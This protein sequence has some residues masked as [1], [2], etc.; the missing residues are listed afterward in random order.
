MGMRNVLYYY[1]ICIVILLGGCHV[2]AGSDTPSMENPDFFMDSLA[3]DLVSPSLPDLTQNQLLDLHH[4]LQTDIS[5]GILKAGPV[6][7][8]SGAGWQNITM[9]AVISAPGNY[10][11]I[12]D[13]SASKEEIGLLITCSD[14]YI[15]GDR[16]TFYGNSTYVCYGIGATALTSLSNITVFNFNTCGCLGGIVFERVIG[17]EISDT[18]HTGDVSGITIGMSESIYISGNSV[19]GHTMSNM[20]HEYFGIAGVD[21]ADINIDSNEISNITPFPED[22]N[23]AGIFLHNARNLLIIGNNITGP[24]TSGG[25]ILS[26]GTNSSIIGNEIT[27][28]LSCGGIILTDSM[29]SHIQGNEITGPSSG[30]GIVLTGSTHS[31]I[32]GNNITGPV[33]TGGITLSNC[34]NSG[35]NGSTI[36]G[37]LPG[38]GIILI[39]DMNS[40]IHGNTVTGQSSGGGIFLNHG[41]N[42]DIHENA[43]TGPSYGIVFKGE[44][45]D[46]SDNTVLS[47]DTVGVS[48]KDGPGTIRNNTVKAC[49]Y[50]IVL[51]MDNSDI[52]RN[53]IHDNL[54]RGLSILGTNLTLSQNKLTNNTCNVYIDGNRIDHYLHHIDHT[55]L[56]NGRPLLYIRD[57]SGDVVG[58]A[59]NPAMV[60]VARSGNVT[61]QNITTGGNIAGIMLANVT[62][63]TISGVTDTG[64]MA[65]FG[66]SW[67]KG[68]TVSDLS[69]TKSNA[70]GFILVEDTDISLDRCQV[71]ETS[72]TGYYIRGS[73]NIVLNSCNITNFTQDYHEE[74]AYGMMIDESG[75]VL[76]QNSSISNSPY[77]GIN[78]M[79][80]RGLAVTN[81]HIFDN[82]E[83]GLAC[84]Q[85]TPIIVSNST[86]Y[87]NNGAGIALDI[88]STFSLN[89]NYIVG[90]DHGLSLLDVSDGLVTDN[91]FNNTQ[92]VRF[93]ADHTPVRWNITHTQGHNIMNGSSLGG[94]FWADP[95]GH[96]FSQTHE[97]RGDGIC[98]AS[99]VLNEQNIDYLPLAVPAEKI[100]PDF[101]ADQYSGTPPLTVR[102]TD[103]STGS[104]VQW[105]WT[106]GDGPISHEQNPVHTYAGIGRYSV[107]LEVTG[108]KGKQEVLR[109]PALITVNSRRITGQSGMLRVD[110]TPQNA[111]VLLDGRY[112]GLTPLQ[113]S[114][115]PVGNHQ[116]TITHEGY[117]DWSGIVQVTAYQR[118]CVPR[119][120]L[121][122]KETSPFSKT[123]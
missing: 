41:N 120:I 11:I 5:T 97:D 1:G 53:N 118:T 35:I 81:A 109:M 82:R 121:R 8:N 101:T 88:L 61:I 26:N 43:I 52:S 48:A 67:S 123:I 16:H 4:T 93:V 86:I 50:G 115:I 20:S 18:H 85:S 47:A 117:Q 22:I 55:N 29:N 51:V 3:S 114:G 23:S 92:N 54:Q 15:E 75:S 104:P 62:G 84:M 65:G 76:I 60:L 14:V 13:Y 25:I 91:F 34:I 103:R 63:G 107:T 69:V 79:N 106:F 39:D 12:N 100:I 40:S 96:G 71:S 31:N 38:G 28:P 17:G 46:I 122:K 27:G 94:N 42:S 116:I 80:T 99:Y 89:R 119:V 36:T 105:N 70:Y 98:N 110:S 68:C 112:I 24:V 64:S 56:I 21:V 78:A 111:S 74:E 37:D 113:I 45:T 10:R 83:S 90:N 77:S 7:I 33:T 66:A 57:S 102:F 19:A 58:P 44:Q 108:Y 6:V 32:E 73:T 72:G 87:D 59:D 95:D 30:G 49:R 9:P 2:T